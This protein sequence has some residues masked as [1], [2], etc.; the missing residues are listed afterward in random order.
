MNFYRLIILSIIF[1]PSLAFSIYLPLTVNNWGK[2]RAFSWNGITPLAL[3]FQT[4]ETYELAIILP[5][6]TE[7]SLKKEIAKDF[8]NQD[9]YV[10]YLPDNSVLDSVD[11]FNLQIINTKKSWPLKTSKTKITKKTSLP[12]LSLVSVSDSV[13]HGGAGL[14][15]VESEKYKDLSTLAFFDENKIPFYPQTFQKDG[16]YTI[17]FS[18]YTDHSTKWTNQYILA[19]DNAG[20]TNTLILSD[21]KP[22]I[23]K[24]RQSTITLPNDYAQQKAKELALSKEAAKALEGDINAINKALATPQRTFERWK[25]TRTTFKANAKHIIKAPIVFSEP[26]LPMSNAVFTGTYGDQR[27]YYYK[28]K[29]VRTSVHRGLDYASYKNTPLYALLDGTIIYADWYGGNG[30]A[31]IIDHGLNT[32]SLYAHNSEILVKEGQKVKAGTQIS[33]SGTTGQSTGDHLHL[34]IFVQGMFVE[35]K[36]WISAKSI[37]ETFHKP[38]EQAS[39]YIKTLTN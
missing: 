8:E 14:V 10:F 3:D 35:P 6:K 31:V 13:E 1:L 37:Q 28:K 36:E 4:G 7:I 29:Q 27:K 22:I 34:S 30:K 38:L 39:E 21:V 16:F 23:R 17:L 20:N 11:E 19:M 32:Y 2:A 9:H 26:S 15:V 12:K 24:Y 5:D 18:W 25:I 33:I